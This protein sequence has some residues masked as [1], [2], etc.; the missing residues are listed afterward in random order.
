[1]HVCEVWQ[2]EVTDMTSGHSYLPNYADFDDDWQP[3][4]R[5]QQVMPSSLC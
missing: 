5:Q 3:Q 4:W 1:M 2:T